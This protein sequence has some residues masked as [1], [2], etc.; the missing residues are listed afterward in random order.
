MVIL[1]SAPDRWVFL[2]L[3]RLKE[4]ASA[5]KVTDL[6]E[7]AA[8]SETLQYD[9][10]AISRDVLNESKRKDKLSFAPHPLTFSMTSCTFQK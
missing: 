3:E 7:I 8:N 1:A 9:V 2:N 4:A 5:E 6:V 10:K